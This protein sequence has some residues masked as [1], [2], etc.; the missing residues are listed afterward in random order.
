MG[1]HNDGDLAGQEEQTGT[2]VVMD[3]AIYMIFDMEYSCH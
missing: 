3:G 1:W 2:V